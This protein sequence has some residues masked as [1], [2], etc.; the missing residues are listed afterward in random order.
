MTDTSTGKRAWDL[1]RQQHLTWHQ[2]ATTLGLR[3]NFDVRTGT[4]EPHWE[5][6]AGHAINHGLRTGQLGDED[7]ADIDPDDAAVIRQMIRAREAARG[8]Q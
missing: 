3:H 1:H 5:A 6:A 7:L 2:I 4:Y 8:A